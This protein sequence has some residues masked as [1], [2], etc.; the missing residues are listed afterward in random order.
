M[1]IDTVTDALDEAIAIKGQIR[2][3]IINRGVAVPANTPFDDYPDKIDQITGILQTKNLVVTAA[4]G[5]VTP[6][7]GYDGFSKVTLPAEPNLIPANISEGVSIFG[8]TGSA[9]T[10]TFDIAA[11]FART[12]TS[13][14][15][16]V[17]TLG[18]Y[19]M[20]K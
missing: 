9:Q 1:A 8:V 2:T 13:L 12:L 19:A 4:G 10:A 15:L 3:S 16:G 11:F 20:Y 18:N 5:D 6:E 7:T 17:A 14:S